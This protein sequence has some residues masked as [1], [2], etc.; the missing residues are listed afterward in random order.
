MVILGITGTDGGGKGTVVDYLAQEKGFVHY[1]ARGI[2]THEITRRG[3]PVNRE[4]MRLIA[5]DLR[6]QH[7]RDVLIQ[8]SL[9]K[10]Q[11]SNDT[12]IV[13]ESLRALAEVEALHREGG[14]LLA[15][16]APQQLRFERIQ[17]RGSASDQVT[18]EEFVKQEAL[19]MSDPD[20]NGM[21]KAAVMQLADVVIQN[22]GTLEELHTEVDRVL[23]ELGISD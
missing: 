13:I 8:M 3:L 17:K 19:E 14:K 1:S 9:G 6:G 18:F 22:N 20:P 2:W 23:V 15:V 4:N 11:A 5:N 12:R 10:A 7:G 16:D 21:Q